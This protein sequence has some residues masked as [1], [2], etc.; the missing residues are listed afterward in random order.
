[1]LLLV[2]GEATFDDEYD[3]EDQY[4]SITGTRYVAR[5]SFNDAFCFAVASLQSGPSEITYARVPAPS[6]DDVEAYH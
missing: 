5:V 1:M 3:H 2:T 6:P 4:D